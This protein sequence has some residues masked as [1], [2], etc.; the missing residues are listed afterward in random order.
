MTRVDAG[1]VAL[2]QGRVYRAGNLP[3]GVVDTLGGGNDF[4]VGVPA[5]H[6]KGLSGHQSLEP[7]ARKAPRN[8]GLALVANE[9][10]IPNI[11]P[12]RKIEL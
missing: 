7:S 2:Q 11:A 10:P 9:S 3:A 12:S 4:I 5:A 8:G 1:S 6:S